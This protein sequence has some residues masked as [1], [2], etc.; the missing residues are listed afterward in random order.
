V[1]H[2]LIRFVKPSVTADKYSESS[3]YT[4]ASMVRVAV[5]GDVWREIIAY[6]L[7]RNCYPYATRTRNWPQVSYTTLTDRIIAVMLVCKLWKVRRRIVRSL[8]PTYLPQQS[9]AEPHLY[10]RLVFSERAG[11]P[12]R[13]ASGLLQ[14]HRC[15]N[16]ARWTREV[17]VTEIYS[18]KLIQDYVVPI[19]AR[20]QYLAKL[21]I[22]IPKSTGG[23][24]GAAMIITPSR[25][26]AMR[27]G[28]FPE[29]H[30]TLPRRFPRTAH[31]NVMQC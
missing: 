31:C 14:Q 30:C 5:P 3:L 11:N 10:H 19:I 22:N 9:L 1:S 18:E 17:E 13:V 8:H 16:L 24:L 15:Q 23:M 28:K 25:H 21:N 29:A 26:N 2:L 27:P 6:H 12:K 20:T 4:P 7:N